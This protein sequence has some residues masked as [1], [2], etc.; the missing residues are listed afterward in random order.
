MEQENIY[1]Q[2]GKAV[3]KIALKLFENKELLKLLQDMSD[4]P[5][6]NVT[7]K[8]NNTL[9][10]KN[11]NIRT[12]PN[13]DTTKV[14]QGVIVVIPYYGMT[15]ENSQFSLSGFSFDIFLPIDKW[16]INNEIQRPYEIMSKIYN[17]VNNS[18]VTGIGV[19]RHDGF[20]LDVVSNEVSLHS[21]KFTVDTVG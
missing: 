8:V 21:M 6:N 17:L 5:F 11:G 2:V 4:D 15:G 7:F 12:V 1:S 3:K 20:E 14:K 13:V 16:Q 10:F 18:R 9:D 19:L